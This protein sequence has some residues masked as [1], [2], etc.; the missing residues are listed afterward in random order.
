VVLFSHHKYS[1]IT[2]FQ[3]EITAKTK[4]EGR[5]HK[6]K[7]EEQKQK[8]KLLHSFRTPSTSPSVAAQSSFFPRLQ[9]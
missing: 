9:F 8:R 5:R 4:I 3:E 2:P 7:P 6:G 1:N